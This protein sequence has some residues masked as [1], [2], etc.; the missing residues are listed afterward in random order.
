MEASATAFTALERLRGVL[1]TTPLVFGEERITVT[2]SIGLCWQAD[3]S[4]DAMLNEA[5]GALYAAKKSG[6][7][8]TEPKPP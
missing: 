2:V 7:N 5:D 3:L 6:R 4:L 1:A 8:R